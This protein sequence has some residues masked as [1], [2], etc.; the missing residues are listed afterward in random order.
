VA[1]CCAGG[2]AGAQTVPSEPITFG[3][4]R[5]VL[6]ADAAVSIGPVDEGFFNYADYEHST[7][8]EFRVGI[9][10]EIRANRR[11][12]VLAEV[13]SQNLD[14]VS[15]FALY[16]RLRPFP[17]RRLDVQAGLIPPTFG[18]FSRHAYSRDN[19]LIGYPLAYQYLTSLRPDALP[20]DADELFR[21]R[22][23]GWLSSFSVG[24]ETAAPGVSLVTGFRWDTGVQVTTG[25]KAVSVTGAVTNGTLSNPRVSDDNSGKQIATRVVFAPYPGFEIGSSFARGAFVSRT[26]LSALDSSNGNDFVQIAHGLDVEYAHRHWVV[27]AEAVAS[28]WRVPLLAAGRLEQLRAVALAVEGRYAILPGV[29]FAARADHLA[30]N[31]IQGSSQRQTWEAPVTRTEIGGGY[32]IQRNVIAR[33]SLQFNRR[34]GGRIRQSELL[35]GQILFWF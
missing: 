25:W 1:W 20:A 3:G 6:G 12:T 28:E 16:V 19:P 24:S 9:T 13:R 18:R 2:I 34:D 4:G 7:L 15:P 10:A 22:G 31:Q 26:A 14:G 32:Y 17:N 23:R 35:A 29:Y 21:M 5:V 33:A 11:L 30:F 8:R 27:R